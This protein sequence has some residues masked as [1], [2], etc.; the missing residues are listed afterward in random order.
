M[1]WVPPA[2]QA[3]LGKALVAEYKIQRLES[4]SVCHR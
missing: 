3:A 2:D 4:C 1:T